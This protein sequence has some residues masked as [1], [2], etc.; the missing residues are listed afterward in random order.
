MN[1]QDPRACAWKT[2]NE[3]ILI[4]QSMCIYFHKERENCSFEMAAPHTAPTQWP[5]LLKNPLDLQGLICCPST[6]GLH[7]PHDS[8]TL[9]HL[10]FCCEA[11]PAG[12]NHEIQKDKNLPLFQGFLFFS[13]TKGISNLTLY[14]RKWEMDTVRARKNMIREK[15]IPITTGKVGR[16]PLAGINTG[17]H[18]TQLGWSL[19]VVKTY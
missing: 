5:M 4:A 11:A 14:G 16:I 13:V 15:I 8:I 19:L 17:E 3:N 2:E 6:T 1:K 7:R 9:S 12:R 10:S 18:V